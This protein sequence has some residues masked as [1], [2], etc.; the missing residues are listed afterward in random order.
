MI[1]L[2]NSERSSDGQNVRFGSARSAV[3]VRPLR[4]ML[5]AELQEKILQSSIKQRKYIYVFFIVLYSLTIFS[6]FIVGDK[7]SVWYGRSALFMLTLTAIPGILGRFKIKIPIT[8]II[9]RFRRHFGILVFMLAFSHSLYVYFLPQ[10]TADKNILIFPRFLFMQF[11][12][13]ALILLSPL[14]LTS[15]NLSQYILK[16]WWKRLHRIIYLIL[17]LVFGHVALQRFSFWSVWIG[18]IAF[19]EIVSLIF[20][21]VKHYNTM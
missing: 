6:W 4:L 7:L 16:K 18:I 8:F 3:Q 21:R 17:W 15:N 9:T 1:K 14:F 12:F 11:G 13:F 19:L 10:L 20:D 2:D 5:S